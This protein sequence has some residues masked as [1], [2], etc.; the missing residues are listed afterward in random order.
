MAIEVQATEFGRNFP[1]MREDVREHG[2]IAVRSHNRLVGAFISPSVMEE[3]ERLRRHQRHL[4]RIEEVD[5]TFLSALDDGLAHY[6]G[7]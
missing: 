4:T 7:A 5:E 6:D 1:K 2:V 3:L